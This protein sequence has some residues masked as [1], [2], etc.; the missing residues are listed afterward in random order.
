MDA[1]A[2][3]APLK[4]EVHLPGFAGDLYGEVLEVAFVRHLRDEQRFPD[5]GALVAQIRQDVARVVS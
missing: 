4:L 2:E 1:G 3:D 5:V